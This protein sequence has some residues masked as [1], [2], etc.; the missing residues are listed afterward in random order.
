MFERKG[1]GYDHSEEN[2]LL[3]QTGQEIPPEHCAALL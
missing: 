3:T 2:Q 1:A